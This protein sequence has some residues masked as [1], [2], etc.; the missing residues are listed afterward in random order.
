MNTSISQNIMEGQTNRNQLKSTDE[1]KQKSTVGQ[2]RRGNL[3]DF[4][5]TAY[6]K[7]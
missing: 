6:Y 4:F 5:H 7:M 1:S 3:G 2:N